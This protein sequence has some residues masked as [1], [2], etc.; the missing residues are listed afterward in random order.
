MQGKSSDHSRWHNITTATSCAPTDIAEGVGCTCL[1]FGERRPTGK[2][3]DLDYA[4]PNGE[5][6]IGYRLCTLA[7]RSVGRFGSTPVNDCVRESVKV[8]QQRTDNGG[9]IGAHNDSSGH[10]K[11]NERVH[12]RL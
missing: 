11:S 2:L 9:G 8:A 10:Q 4:I 5:G 1:T 7:E 3:R 12:G 6:S